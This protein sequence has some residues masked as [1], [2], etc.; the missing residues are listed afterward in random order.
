MENGFIYHAVGQLATVYKI[1]PEEN[2]DAFK[3]EILEKLGSKVYKRFQ[4]KTGK[5]IFEKLLKVGNKSVDSH[6]YKVLTLLGF[7]IK[8]KKIY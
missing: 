1:I 3:L 7:D 8:L 6:K 2:K 5:K 4:Q